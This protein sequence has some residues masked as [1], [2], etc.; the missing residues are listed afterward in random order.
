MAYTLEQLSADCRA[1]L[2]ENPGTPGREKVRDCIA[3]ACGDAEFAATHLGEDVT[4]ERNILYEDPDLKFCILAH[5]YKGPK[6]SQPHDHGPSWAIYGQVFGTTVMTDWKR[7][8]E[9]K[10]GQPG[11]VEKIKSYAM[12]PGDA[13]LYDEKVLHSP[14]RESETRLIRVEGVNMAGVKRDKFEVAA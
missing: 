2:T 6:K 13:Y 7:V 12:N 14:S 10:D 8:E 4:V 9:P 11:K 5:V 1:A 3:R